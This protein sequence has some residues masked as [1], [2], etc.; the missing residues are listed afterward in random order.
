MS[1]HNPIQ[2]GRVRDQKWPVLHDQHAEGTVGRKLTTPQLVSSHTELV[3]CD[4]VELT[5][6]WKFKIAVFVI[7]GDKEN[8]QMGLT[9]TILAL[10]FMQNNKVLFH[11]FLQ[12]YLGFNM[13]R[14]F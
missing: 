5:W 11:A 14:I 2:G 8:G 12:T 6:F 1:D 3:F 10:I 7:R 9:F 4:S 13:L